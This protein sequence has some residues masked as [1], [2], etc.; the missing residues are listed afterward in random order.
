MASDLMPWVGGV[1][2]ALAL[3]FILPREG[4]RLVTYVVLA[5]LSAAGCYLTF[6]LEPEFNIAQILTVGLGYV[7]LIFTVAT[8]LIGPLNLLRQRR[9]PVNI[10]LRRDTGIWAA[11]TGV[12]HVW[13]GFQV[14]LGGEIV[15]Y[16]FE[17]VDHGYRPLLNLFGLSNYVG[18][19]ATLV[20]VTL[21]TLSN[22][23][24]LRWL[25]GGW[26]KWLQRLNYILILLVVA[27]TF[28]Y[29]VVVERALIL[30]LATVGLVV[31]VLAAQ[32]TGILI[33]WSRRRRTS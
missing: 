14:H 20:L 16:F 30:P 2:L 12:L 9:N 33:S 3:G 27:H 4:K 19:A 23:L 25:K 32:A 13:F 29:Q 5:L 10:N 18:A 6:L 31:L 7:A 8:L 17:V 28:G 21:L 24:T 11:I 22:D 26:W 1:L 15:R